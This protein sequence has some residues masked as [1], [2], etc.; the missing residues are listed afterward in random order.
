M[1]TPVVM[2]HEMDDPSQSDQAPSTDLTIRPLE[3]SDAESV[4]ELLASQPTDYLRFFYA[5]SSDPDALRATLQAKRRDVYAGVFWRKRLI[6]VFTLRGWD[7]GYDVPAFGL[8]VAADQ[9]GNAVVTGALEVAKVIAR[10][11][12]S[13]RMMCKVHPE[14]K[15]A[16]TAAL[17][18]GFVGGAEE[19]R[20]GNIIYHI[21][22]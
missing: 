10:L 18:L 7:E 8:V 19:P 3:G 12:G 15:A 14:N 20:T 2:E 9:R 6:C 1:N 22:L 11:S 21:D 16:T 13:S 4:T 5:F 17:R